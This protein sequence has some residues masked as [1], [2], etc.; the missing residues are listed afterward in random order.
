[1]NP[2]TRKTLRISTLFALIATLLATTRFAV[3]TNAQHLQQGVSVQLAP[4]NNALPMPAADNED[5]WIVAI[6]ADGKVYFGVDPVDPASLADVMK[7]RPRK[8]EQMLYIKADA[9]TPFAN[10]ARV[11]E[12]GRKVWFDSPILLTSQPQSSQSGMVAPRGLLVSLRQPVGLETVGVQVY[13]SDQNSPAV[14]IN[15]EQVS[16]SSLQT[17]LG[18]ILPNTNDKTALIKADGQLPFDQVARV[19]D[20]CAAAGFRAVLVTPEL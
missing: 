17:K 20:A 7:S 5:A 18:Q 10:V 12:A 9:R 3:P 15:N 13:R 8:R 11:L 14:K 4:T 2:R 19:L 6:T 1:M 16:W